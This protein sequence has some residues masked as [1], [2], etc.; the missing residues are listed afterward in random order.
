MMAR[1]KSNIVKI[2]SY[3]NL[4]TPK[5][6]EFAR[7]NSICEMLR[8]VVDIP[9]RTPLP[10]EFNECLEIS[11]EGKLEGFDPSLVLIFD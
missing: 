1:D 4:E 11:I 9:E 8:V 7:Y 6:L 3:A 2:L 5:S 10:Y